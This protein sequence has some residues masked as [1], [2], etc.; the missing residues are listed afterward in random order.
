MNAEQKITFFKTT[1]KVMLE[2]DWEWFLERN[3]SYFLIFL[4][5]FDESNAQTCDGNGSVI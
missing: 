5:M 1:E 3:S 2:K 4:E